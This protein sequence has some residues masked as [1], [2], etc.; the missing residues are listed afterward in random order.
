MEKPIVR[1]LLT[2]YNG[3]RY[4]RS[5]IDS[6]MEQDYENWELI[7]SDDGSGDS[8]VA[9]LD[10]YAHNN[11]DR[12][13][14]HR[15]GRR[16]GCAQKHFMH[17][18]R[19]FSDAPYIM[20]CDQDDV[21]HRD[22]VSKTL[23]CMLRQTD[24][25]RP[26]LVH[27]DLRVVDQD[28]KELAPSFC[29]H[30][31]LDGNRTQLAQLLVQNV[32]TGCTMMLNQPLVMLACRACEE[33][34]M[35]MHDWWIGLIAAAFGSVEFLPEATIDYRQHGTNS[36]GAKDVHSVSYLMHRLRS[37]KMRKALQKA[38]AQAGAF[39]DCFADQLCVQQMELLRAFA[40]TENAN[41]WRRNRIYLDYGL[42]KAG[43]I[44]RTAQLLG[45]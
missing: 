18:L 1:I 25:T 8:T 21:W 38:A 37:A 16:F 45:L 2:T 39:A 40:A 35:L 34:K 28:L 19:T 44:R 4:I 29:A 22:K 32:I 27:T 23:Q 33:E 6:I 43:F 15:S 20:F 11:P 42:L 9:I 36:V 5:M 31:A 7:V 14:H 12:I 41:I 30:S 17:L 3:E 24:P 26:T 13:T 10:E